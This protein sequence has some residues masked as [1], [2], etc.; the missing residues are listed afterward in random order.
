MR[1]RSLNV[2]RSAKYT[3]FHVTKLTQFHLNSSIIQL[4]LLSNLRYVQAGFGGCI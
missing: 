2:M 4:T 3:S 1:E